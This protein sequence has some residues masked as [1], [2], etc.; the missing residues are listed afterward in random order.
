MQ[1]WIGNDWDHHQ[2]LESGH[3]GLAKQ[4]AQPIAALLKDLKQQGMLDD[5]LVICGGGVR[6]HP[7]R[8]IADGPAQQ[9]ARQRPRP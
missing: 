6:P 7:D 1:A 4:C 3:R 2:N 8:G 9:L 5:T